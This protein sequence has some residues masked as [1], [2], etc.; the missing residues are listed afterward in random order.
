M[1]FNHWWVSA[2]EKTQAVLDQFIL[3]GMSTSLV[4]ERDLVLSKWLIF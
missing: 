1:I 4:P 2:D 3:F